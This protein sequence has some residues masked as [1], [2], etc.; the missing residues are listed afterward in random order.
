MSPILVD[1]AKHGWEVPKEWLYGLRF[2]MFIQ[3][4]SLHL[5]HCICPTAI[6][7]FFPNLKSHYIPLLS[8]HYPI[9][10]ISKYQNIPI[11]PVIRFPVFHLK[12]R[13]ALR[14]RVWG[15]WKTARIVLRRCCCGSPPGK[16]GVVFGENQGFFSSIMG[17]L[18][19]YQEK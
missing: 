6:S 17:Q 11:Y 8:H 13:Q 4:V 2:R 5:S 9:V 15:I 19:F 10:K 1:F 3:Q 18:L 16:K 14:R 12:L 7:L